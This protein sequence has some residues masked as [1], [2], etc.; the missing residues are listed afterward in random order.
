MWVNRMCEFAVLNVSIFVWVC[1]CIKKF[2]WQFQF[3]LFLQAENIISASWLFLENF[4]ALGRYL[5]F[6][7]KD[8]FMG[9]YLCQLEKSI[10]D[11]LIFY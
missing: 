10:F 3:S 7:C 5:K 11:L 9:K 2:Q 6:I 8:D 4:D 1:P